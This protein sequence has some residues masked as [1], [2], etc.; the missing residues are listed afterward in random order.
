[1]QRTTLIPRQIGRCGAAVAAGALLLTACGGKPEQKHS[2]D[3]LSTL[4]PAGVKAAGV[5]RIGSDL[6]YAPV[7]FKGPDQQAV[8]LDPEIAEAVGR[9]LGL[10]VEFI[11]TAFDK[12]IP[13]L[14]AK[15]YDV[16]MS[17]MS[18]NRQRREG[19]DDADGPAGPGLDFADYFIAGTSILVRKGNPKA[20]AG[21]DDLCGHTVALQRGTTQATVIDRQTVACTKAGKPLKVKLF[22]N[23][24]LALAELAAGRADADLNDYPVAAYVAQQ[25]DGGKTF[26]I[27]GAQLQPG[28]YGIALTKESTALRD[29]LLKALN[30]IIRSGEY[31]KI[32]AKWNVTDGAV[33]NAV[34]NG[35]F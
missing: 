6:N 16:V 4:V 21:L 27:A 19:T 2:T 31:D 12:L 17:A 15:Q 28:P 14:H 20:I 30:R 35:G 7:E 22:E 18:D 32:L 25:R 10:R 11:D 26:Q 8:G 1:M 24:D 29:V 9:E 5:L 33:Q 13:G 34:A 3:D 23:D